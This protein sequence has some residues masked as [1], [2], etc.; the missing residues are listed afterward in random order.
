MQVQNIITKGFHSVVLLAFVDYDYKL[1]I[2]EVG[3]QG[4]ISDGGVDRNSSFFAALQNDKLH[5][6]PPQ[7]LAQNDDPFWAGIHGEKETP[8][9]FVGDNAFPLTVNPYGQKNLKDENRIYNYRLSR[10]RRRSENAFGIWINRFR[11]FAF[12]A[13]LCPEGIVKTIM[14]SLVLHN[15][16]RTKSSDSYPPPS[17]V[18]QIEGDIVIPGSWREN[19][20]PQNV[21]P[22]PP[23]GSG[24]LNFKAEKVG[25]TFV[26]YFNGP[27]QVP[28]QWQ[29]Q[30]SW[31]I[32]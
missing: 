24:R 8:V 28:W 12:T 23:R 20:I 18:D 26:E 5:L 4:R 29:T 25:E 30:Y 15:L 6:P 19:P 1:L 22:L 32:W 13:L 17:F 9:V 10:F 27:G 16:L 31:K 2:A 11:L 21:A 3:C 7:K 14:A